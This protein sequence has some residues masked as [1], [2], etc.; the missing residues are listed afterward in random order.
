L[1][2]RAILWW[3]TGRWWA[4]TIK[5][6]ALAVIAYNVLAF[7]LMW[8]PPVRGVVVD[9]D[10]GAPID[11]AIVQ[12][13]GEGPFV[14]IY[15][16]TPRGART[17]GAYAQMTTDKEGRFSFSAAFAHPTPNGYSWLNVL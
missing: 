11:G 13:M 4:K 12:K 17:G 6:M 1:C 15:S 14:F 16:E 7:V 9:I 5:I 10:S 8:C 3:F 2:T